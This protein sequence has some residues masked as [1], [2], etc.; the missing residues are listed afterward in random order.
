VIVLDASATLDWLL[1][2]PAGLKVEQR[3]YGRAEGVH[4]PHLLDLEVA[5]VLRRFAREGTISDLR[6]EVALGD[7][8]DARVTRHPH[9]LLLPRVWQLRHN[10]TA[11]DAV[12][13]ALAELLNASLVT[14]DR[15]IGTASGHRAQI[16]VV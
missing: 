11:Y 3:I 14:R 13:V 5:Q 1:R 15:R 10:L 6:A 9:R 12:Y 7:L 4:A 2:T 8:A 16:E